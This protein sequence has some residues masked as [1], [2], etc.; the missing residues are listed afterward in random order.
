MHKKQCALKLI[1]KERSAVKKNVSNVGKV[2]L[3]LKI[4][5]KL[6]KSHLPRIKSYSMVTSK[7]LKFE[8]IQVF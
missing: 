8:K 6:H 5:A 4:K 3:R 7:L 1:I 2:N